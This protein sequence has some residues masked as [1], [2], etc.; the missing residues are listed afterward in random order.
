MEVPLSFL[1]LTV[2]L[3]PKSQNKKKSKKNISEQHRR[4]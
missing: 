4:V 3:N 2:Q 1:A